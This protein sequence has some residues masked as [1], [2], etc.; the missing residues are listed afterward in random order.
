MNKSEI[1]EEMHERT[2]MTK[3][4]IRI[5]LEVLSEVI[6]DKLRSA[7]EGERIPVL[8]K[9]ISVYKKWKAATKAR[10]MNTGITDGPVRVPAK[11]AHWVVK[12]TVRKGLKDAPV[13][14][15]SSSTA[16]P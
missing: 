9:G 2:G 16:C 7:D 12:A 5:F 6:A 14:A 11:P 3:S 4:D 1:V 13:K 8:P 10:T 15:V